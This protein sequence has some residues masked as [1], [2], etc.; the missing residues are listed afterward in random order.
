MTGPPVIKEI[1]KGFTSIAILLFIILVVVLLTAGC[2]GQT[3]YQIIPKD[4]YVFLEH[5]IKEDGIRINGSNCSPRLNIDFPMY[6]F[7]KNSKKLSISS[8]YREKFVND[9]LILVYGHGKSLTGLAGSGAATS[10]SPV[11]SLPSSRGENVTLDSITADGTV[12]FRYNNR[13]LSLKPDETWENVTRIVEKNRSSYSS[14]CIVEYVTTDCF[15]N[16]G[17][18]DKRNIS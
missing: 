14:G 16:A 12:F 8:I 6:F 5:H 18:L 1:G 17:I 11:Y 4:K 7:D 9:S 2:T 3:E 13:H 10:P 15:Y